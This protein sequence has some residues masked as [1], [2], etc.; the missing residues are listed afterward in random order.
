MTPPTMP[1]YIY[2]LITFSPPVFYLTTT[3]TSSPSPDCMLRW[4]QNCSMLLAFNSGWSLSFL[5]RER[6]LYINTF[7]ISQYIIIYFS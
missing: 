5:S 1:A 3:L 4:P 6:E 7:P 2:S